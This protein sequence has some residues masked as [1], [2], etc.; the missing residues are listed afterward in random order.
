VDGNR[1]VSGMSVTGSRSAQLSPARIS[2]PSS[3]KI[4]QLFWRTHTSSSSRYSQVLTASRRGL[5]AV[6]LLGPL[7]Q[8]ETRRSLVSGL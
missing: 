3:H 2:D 4:H 1:C 5:A 8:D 7:F 6:S